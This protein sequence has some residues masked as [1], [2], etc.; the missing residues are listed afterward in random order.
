MCII[1][2]KVIEMYN[3]YLI[4]ITRVFSYLHLYKAIILLN[5]IMYIYLTQKD[6]VKFISVI[7]E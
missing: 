3:N 4:F 1:K 2:N 7:L 6:V 5:I